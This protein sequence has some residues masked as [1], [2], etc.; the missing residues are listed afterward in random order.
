MKKL[1]TGHWLVQVAIGA[2][3]A[4]SRAAILGAV[5]FVAAGL[6]AGPAWAQATAQ[7]PGW[8]RQIVRAQGTL[9]Y[10]QPQVDDWENFK[11]LHWR[12]AISL[13]PAGAKEVV[14]VVV[15]H[16]D[17]SVNSETQMVL[18]SNLQVDHTY[19][20]SA[21][22]ADAAAL[23]GV[24]RTFVP[25]S[26]WITMQRLVA[27]VPKPSTPPPGVQLNNEP[28][29]IL[30][31]YKPAILLSVE[32]NTMFGDVP[33][34]KL[35]Y[36]INTQWALF[37]Y[38]KSTYYLLAGE[39]W[40]MAPSL[41]GPWAPA[42][43]LPDDMK[44]LPKEQLWT[45]LAAYIPPPA[46]S[47]NAPIPTVFYSSTPAVVL[48]FNGQPVYTPI[49]GTQLVY[50]TNTT[51]YVFVYTP[52]KQFYYMT[53]GRW[54]TASSLA[55]PWTFASASLPADFAHI[56]PDSPAAQVLSSVPG[57]EEAKDAV[58]IAQVPT[59]ITVN[60]TEAAAKASVTYDGSPEFVPITGT[61]LSYATNTA[62]KVIQVG[63]LYY[64]C[65]QGIWFVSA[66]PTGPWLTADTVPQVIYTI[67]PSSPV[68]N[69]TYVTQVVGPS[70]TVQSSYTAGYMGAFVVGVAV[71][72]VVAGGTGYYY[73][74]Y[75]YHPAY[76][77][78]VYHP[79]P[80][81]YG[82]S[83]AY[84]T[85][86]G[87]YGVSQTAYGPYGSATRSASYNPYTGTS[88]HSASVSTPYGSA[89]AASAYNPYT[90]AAAATHQGSNG[91]SSWGSSA[92]VGKNGESAYSQ[93][94]S[95]A[96]G[97]VGSV[98]TS[99]GGKAVGATGAY[100]NTATA[101]KASN[102]NMYASSDGNVYKN[103][104]SGWEKAGSNGSWTPVNS[105]SAQEKS[106]ASSYEQ[107]HP[108][109]TSSYQQQHPS[110]T[111]SSSYQKPAGSESTQNM[112]QEAQN[113]QRGEQSSQRYSQQRSS[114]GWGGGGH[115]R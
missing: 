13:T 50:A 75:V 102:G 93:H 28:P 32:G 61:T 70:G 62:Q 111:G 65:L 105:S 94:Y 69:V 109:S 77:Y 72:A 115:R 4:A 106:S 95:T 37:L 96:Q 110:S 64:L 26:V 97:S 86:T 45:G 66:S 88:T 14:G 10:Y 42:A 46:S 100:G 80:T 31:S 16:G 27:C 51:S 85:S 35:Q 53:G 6:S 34:T 49:Q 25:P 19:F 44:K 21:S 38:D 103:T 5:F 68:Y 55:G 17:T 7:D 104:G 73:P 30:A 76:G 11:K 99:A 33:K 43:T 3:K 24:V 84:R 114:G 23:D 90:G 56:P 107:Q 67:P 1:L 48:L 12:M 108:S 58:M 98:Q 2:A 92:A 79:Y 82:Y 39:R 59:S 71:G 113:R 9:V 74:P 29:K 54:F 87:A 22:P 8:P 20:P 89:G 91:Y 18:I 78:P 60:A 81:T 41:D 112:Q 15:L 63:N 40:L 83:T 52:T 36:V 47:A 57:T 101:G